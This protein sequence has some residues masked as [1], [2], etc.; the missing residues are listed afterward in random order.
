MFFWIF[1]KNVSS[2]GKKPVAGVRETSNFAQTQIM[3]CLKKHLK[4]TFF[5]EPSNMVKMESEI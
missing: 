4:I 2:E 3:S 5:P 1:V